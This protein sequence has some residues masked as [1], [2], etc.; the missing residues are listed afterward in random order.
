MEE[1]NSWEIVE[2]ILA[3]KKRST[4]KIRRTAKEKG[5][6]RYKSRISANVNVK[7]MMTVTMRKKIFLKM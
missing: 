4:D 1:G 3:L 5:S 6:C 2:P 7:V